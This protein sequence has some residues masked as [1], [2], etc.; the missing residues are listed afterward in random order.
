MS[1]ETASETPLVFPPMIVDK[2]IP[3]QGQGS[4]E[5]NPKENSDNKN[6][7]NELLGILKSFIKNWCH[8]YDWDSYRDQSRKETESYYKDLGSTGKT[9]DVKS[10]KSDDIPVL[11]HHTKSAAN[12][13]LKRS[14]N[15]NGAISAKI[16]YNGQL[17]KYLV[18]SNTA[19]VPSTVKY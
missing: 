6:I 11:I 4:S 2:S 15:D 3:Q 12:A 19:K 8:K 17:E 1:E 13:D 7:R 16:S 9:Q 18:S 14:T 5:I 10:N